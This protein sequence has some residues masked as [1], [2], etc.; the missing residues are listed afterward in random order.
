[1]ALTVGVGVRVAVRTGVR[2]RGRRRER[3]ERVVAEAQPTRASS[4]STSGKRLADERSIRRSHRRGSRTHP[5]RR[6][7][8]P[9]RG[10][11]RRSDRR[12]RHS[13]CR[14]PHGACRPG[15]VRTRRGS[16]P[17][18]WRGRPTS[19]RRGWRASVRRRFRPSSTPRA[20]CRLRRH[21]RSESTQLRAVENCR[22]RSFRPLVA[23][24][25][26]QRTVCVATGKPARPSETP[27]GGGSESAAVARARS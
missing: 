27:S 24:A 6:C 4:V 19:G 26:W 15:A 5:S 7:P 11:G 17:A 16:R 25:R 20:A 1:M 18:S 21:L 8:S 22:D 12:S 2:S 14:S 3:A 10:R 13:R 23:T 9:D